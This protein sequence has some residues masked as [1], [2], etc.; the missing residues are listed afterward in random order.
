[1]SVLL[2]Y[3]W[4][5]QARGPQW[6]SVITNF[7]LPYFS[8]C[9]SLNILLTAMIVARLILYSRDVRKAMGSSAGTSGLYKAVITMLIESSALYTAGFLLFFPPWAANSSAADLFSLLLADIQVRTGLNFSDRP[10][11]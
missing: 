11:S 7:G 2:T 9:L 1:M 10:R 6:T 8:I 4:A 3:H 5:L